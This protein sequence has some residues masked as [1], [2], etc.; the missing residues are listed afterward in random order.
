MPKP[1]IDAW[2]WFF[3]LDWSRLDN[4][5]SALA[6]MAALVGIIWA[7]FRFVVRPL[8]R[9]IWKRLRRRPAQ[10]K[11]LDKLVCGSS[12]EY[13]ESMFGN[14]HLVTFVD[15][16]EQRTYHLRG[17]WV[18]VEIE[19]GRVIA[20][21]ITITDRDM[22]YNTKNLTR[23]FLDFDLGRDKFPEHDL[24]CDG[25]QVWIGAYRRGYARTYYMG[26]PAAYLRF[27][28]SHNMAGTG[29][30][31]S[32]EPISGHVIA[33]GQFSPTY[34]Q[35]YE[36]FA[37]PIRGNGITANTLT[38]IHPDAPDREFL[39][40]DVHGPDESHMGLATSIRPP[41]NRTIRTRLAVGLYQMKNAL[42]KLIS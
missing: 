39:S 21:S 25:E 7:A 41:D 15:E 4:I 10:A 19:N 36:P 23:G 32:G 13:V 27:V 28:V 11:L 33:S 14:A 34:G 5:F 35:S 38:V 31:D 18:M 30:F 24:H 20:F 6:A 29:D 9:L 2:N 17:A 22:A 26:R 1:L 12:V 37:E 42:R 8:W 3:A 40:R 16:R